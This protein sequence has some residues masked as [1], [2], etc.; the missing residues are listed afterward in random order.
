[1]LPLG[2]SL[3]FSATRLIRPFL[4]S[5]GPSAPSATAQGVK[6]YPIR[7]TYEPST[8]DHRCN[9]YNYVLYPYRLGPSAKLH[10]HSRPR[11]LDDMGIELSSTPAKGGVDT[12]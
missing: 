10:K 8:C 6:Y 1:M 11:A 4:C 5:L 3:P 12:R 9:D 2:K 7:I